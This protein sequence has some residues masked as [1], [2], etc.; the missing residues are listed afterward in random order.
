MSSGKWDEVKSLFFRALEHGPAGREEYLAQ[1]VASD[2]EIVNIVRGLLSAND[3]AGSILSESAERLDDTRAL[4]TQLNAEDTLQ[5]SDG[6]VVA[7]RY[8]INRYIARGGMGEVYEAND[9]D[10]GIVVAIKAIRP[11]VVSSEEM[12]ARFKREIELARRVT[13]PNIGR[14]YDFGRH[15]GE[16]N[17]EIAFLTMEFLHGETLSQRISRAGP[18]P[19][20]EALALIRDIAAGLDAIHECGIVHRDFKSANVMLVKHNERTRAKVMDFGLARPSGGE[21]TLT[22]TGQIGGTPAYMPPE[23][24]ENVVTAASDIYAL[25][26]VMHEVM[27]GVR[28]RSQGAKSNPA[29]AQLDPVWARVIERCIAIDPAERYQSGAEVVKALTEEESQPLAAMPQRKR[30][31]PKV[32]VASCLVGLGIVAGLVWWVAH[33]VIPVEAKP[34]HLALLPIHVDSRDAADT[35]LCAGLGDTLRGDLAELEPS[36]NSLWVIPSSEVREI[37]TASEAYRTV[38][39]N[40]VVEA[41]FIRLPDGIVFNMELVDPK[42]DRV[43]KSDRL[44]AVDPTALREEAL[45][46]IARLLDLQ[47]SRS[48]SHEVT[49]TT[50]NEPGAFDFYEQGLG[51][52]QREGVENADRSIELFSKALAKDPA[53]ALGFAGLGQA[54]AKKYMLTSD[55]QWMRLA[56]D[57]GRKAIALNGSLAEVHSTLGLIYRLTGKFPEAEAELKTALKIEPSCLLC[58]YRLGRLYVDQGRFPE[59]ERNFQAMIDRHHGDWMGVSGLALVNHE[60]GHLNKAAA[61]YQEEVELTPDSAHALANLGGVYL[62]LGRF[63]D[64]SRVFERALRLRENDQAYSNLGSALMYQG[65]YKEAVAMMDKAVHLAPENHMWWRNLGDSYRQVPGNAANARHAYQEALSKASAQL[66]VRPN[67]ADL[68]S[69]VALYY[70]HLGDNQKAISFASKARAQK[71]LSGDVLFTLAITSELLGDRKDAIKTLASAWK[72]GY[73]LPNIENEAELRDLQKDTRYREW[74]KSAKTANPG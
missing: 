59:A 49:E 55:P 67:D 39:A 51:Y 1:C 4:N 66:V 14:I 45:P 57:N 53:Y 46:H 35:A 16:D 69:S 7:G 32:W 10:L 71:P 8:R 15:V 63:D 21:G 37:K 18:F 34:K 26:V 6:D 19:K 28:P 36:A 52:M 31:R 43:I 48:A 73:P 58:F 27:T 12:L 9:R 50:T 3:D 68:L 24:F 30:P 60:L 25:G 23:Q 29:V 22:Q 5:F 41:S 11:S 13:H 61:L 56:S 72:A 74:D 33:N 38:G 17:R 47:V 62:E 65:R 44:R 64:A 40:L 70:A 2:P 42:S 54:Y 20:D